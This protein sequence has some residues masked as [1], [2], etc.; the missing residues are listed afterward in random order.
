MYT[1]LFVI[2]FY[3]QNQDFS[4]FFHCRDMDYIPTTPEKSTK[5]NFPKAIDLIFLVNVS[6]MFR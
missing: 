5:S 4:L 6:P 1:V 2:D 3:S